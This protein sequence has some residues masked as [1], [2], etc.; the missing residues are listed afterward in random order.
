MDTCDEANASEMVIDT[1]FEPAYNDNYGPR[2]SESDRP[3]SSRAEFGP[4]FIHT[5]AASGLRTP[6]PLHGA[7]QSIHQ[8]AVITSFFH[9]ARVDS[10]LS[11]PVSRNTREGRWKRP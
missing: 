2:P 1:E 5:P 11:R 10:G 6:T 9:M 7:V 4:E 3:S 8:A